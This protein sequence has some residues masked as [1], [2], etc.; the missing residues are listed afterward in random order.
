MNPLT[1]HLQTAH[2]S[3][4]WTRRRR[5][6]LLLWHFAWPL[7]CG[8]TPKPANAW[9]LLVLRLFGT[10]IQGRPFVHSRARIAQPWNLTLHDRAC[11]G[12]NAHA[13]SLGPIEIGAGATIAQEGYLCTGTHDFSSPHL[14][15]Q[16][17][18]IR[19]GPGAFVG[20]RSFILPGVELGARCI[21]GAAS[22]V[23]RDVPADTVVAGNPARI[24]RRR[25]PVPAGAPGYVRASG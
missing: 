16:T 24:I 1:T 7:L 19:V 21:V 11:L 14:D 23:T 13:Y 20:A 17:A 18:L 8:W 3:S 22:V 4:P 15:L 10:Q 6:G 2:G 9:R 25:D 12:D 5:V